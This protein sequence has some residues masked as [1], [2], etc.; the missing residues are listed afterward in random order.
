MLAPV[1]PLV[2]L[3]LAARAAKAIQSGADDRGRMTN[4][5][6]S[7]LAIHTIGSVWLIACMIFVIWQSAA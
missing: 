2:L 4:A 3:A 5:I 6:E 7:T 1:V